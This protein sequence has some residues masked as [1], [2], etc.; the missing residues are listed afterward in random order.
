[1]SLLGK[2]GRRRVKSKDELL[3][4]K[5][6]QKE[7]TYLGED[8]VKEE[9][10]I[11]EYVCEFCGESFKNPQKL[12]WHIRK[13]HKGE[14]PQEKVEEEAKEEGG[15]PLG[16]EKHAEEPSLEE[17]I[18]GLSGQAALLTNLK[19]FE[20]TEAEADAIDTGVELITNTVMI[21]LNKVRS[22]EEK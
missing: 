15:E 20:L 3:E 5:I 13:E 18:Y 8:D 14:K 1:M 2:R 21:Y 9:S 6:R 22:R 10:E 4:E 11:K 17:V 7:K 19:R 12:S 16:E